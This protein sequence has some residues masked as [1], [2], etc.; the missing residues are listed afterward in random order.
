MTTIFEYWRNP[1]TKLWYFHLRSINGEII[2]A[3]EGY[4]R[5]IDLLRAI[6]LVT[7]SSFSP[8]TQISRD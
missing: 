1:F 6:S 7:D 2:A 8:I 3:S 4:S 5:K